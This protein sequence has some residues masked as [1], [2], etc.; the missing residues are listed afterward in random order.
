VASDHREAG[1]KVL[2]GAVGSLDDLESQTEGQGHS[3]QAVG[4]ITED[5]GI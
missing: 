4:M 2:Q 1:W 5:S 3:K